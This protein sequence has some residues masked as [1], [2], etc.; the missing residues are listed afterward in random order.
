VLSYFDYVVRMKRKRY[1]YMPR[2]GQIARIRQIGRARKKCNDNIQDDCYD[3]IICNA[4][5]TCLSAGR[6]GGAVTAVIKVDTLA[7]DRSSR[8]L[9]KLGCRY[10]AIVDYVNVAKAL[11]HNSLTLTV[12]QKHVVV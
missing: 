5:S 1:M 10:T 9:E 11:S 7:G 2:R 8:R 6:I 3:T 12:H 4:H